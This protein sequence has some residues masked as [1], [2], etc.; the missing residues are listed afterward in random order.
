MTEAAIQSK[1][2]KFLW[3]KHP[4]TRWLCYHIP[5]E[6][7]RTGHSYMIAMGM[8]PGIPDYKVDFPASGFS[9]LF[10]EFKKHGEDPSPKQLEVHNILRKNNHK[11]E[12]ARS[13]E[14]AYQIFLEYAKETEYL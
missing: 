9:S 1:F 14:E 2:H 11:V 3:N 12:I 8:I 4:K 13:V 10:I 5:N 7:K 6:A